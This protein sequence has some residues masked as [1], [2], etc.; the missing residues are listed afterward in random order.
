MSHIDIQYTKKKFPVLHRIMTI[1]PGAIALS[2]IC[3]VF[4]GYTIFASSLPTDIPNLIFV[5]AFFIITYYVRWIIRGLEYAVLIF[6]SIFHLQQ[7][8]K[9]DF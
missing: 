2:I 8:E 5:I 1:L 4:V 3:L 9:R 7:Y 6:Q